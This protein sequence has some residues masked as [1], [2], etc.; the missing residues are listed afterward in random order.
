MNECEKAKIDSHY[1][2]IC[3]FCWKLSPYVRNDI[4]A[5][6]GVVYETFVAKYQNVEFNSFS[7]YTDEEYGEI[8]APSNEIK[9]FTL[10]IL[11]TGD[12]MYSSSRDHFF[13]INFRYLSC[14][15]CGT[16]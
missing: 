12:F 1:C 8:K 4:L 3:I 2:L 14:S 10:I 11:C 9:S 16:K 13:P 6:N 7:I 5:K 15:Q